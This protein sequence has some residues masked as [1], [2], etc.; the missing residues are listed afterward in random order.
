[1]LYVGFECA[2]SVFSF[3]ILNHFEKDS[4]VSD[5]Y[6]KFVPKFSLCFFLWVFVEFMN[7]VLQLIP[8]AAS[9]RLQE[10][11]IGPK[12]VVKDH[13]KFNW[14]FLYDRENRRFRGVNNFMRWVNI[15][16]CNPLIFTYLGRNC[17]RVRVF[18]SSGIELFV[19]GNK[20]PQPCHHNPKSPENFMT[21]KLVLTDRQVMIKSN[22]KLALFRINGYGYQL[23][24]I[25]LL[26][27]PEHVNGTD[28]YVV[29][30][31][32]FYVIT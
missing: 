2:K 9:D 19:G 4:I 26:I 7:M 12:I 16:W 25:H 8:L 10:Y 29:R 22:M 30:S 15:K 32:K 28:D 13:E 21:D 24:P 1:M 6:F 23:Q 18:K 31:P 17:F 11:S 3:F 20:Y 27:E 5:L 14:Y